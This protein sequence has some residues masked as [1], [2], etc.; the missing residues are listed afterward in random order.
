[1]SAYASLG[2]AGML[3]CQPVELFTQLLRLP[4]GVGECGT[5]G[6][7]NVERGG[8]PAPPRSYA[9]RDASRPPYSVGNC[10]FAQARMPPFKFSALLYPVLRSIATILPLRAPDRQ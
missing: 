1:M 5:G 10:A 9:A 3:C 7:R 8:A 6:P 2:A 4:K